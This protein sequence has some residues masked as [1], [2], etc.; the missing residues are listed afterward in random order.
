MIDVEVKR[1][2]GHPQFA[3]RVIREVLGTPVH[4]GIGL[5]RLPDVRVVPLPSLLGVPNQQVTLKIIARGSGDVEFRLL[6]PGEE[7]P[8]DAL[9]MPDLPHRDSDRSAAARSSRLWL[10]PRSTRR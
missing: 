9:R 3:F 6:A 8:P 10:P 1:F 5:A 4:L 2:E 7:L